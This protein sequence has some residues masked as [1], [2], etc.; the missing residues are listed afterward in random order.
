MVWQFR[1]KQRPVKA[2]KPK[3][4]EVSP[5]PA[6]VIQCQ[7]QMDA[8]GAPEA[9]LVYWTV[10]SGAV[11]FRVKRDDDLLRS[12]G[13]V[14]EEVYALYGDAN[15]PLPVPG[16]TSELASHAAFVDHL[17][18]AMKSQT[19][20][21]ALHAQVR[22]AFRG[23]PAGSASAWLPLHKPAPESAIDTG[24]TSTSHSLGLLSEK[25]TKVWTVWCCHA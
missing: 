15:S 11:A 8:L 12:M 13:R 7:M 21:W 1:G 18:R 16:F 3:G 5:S 25:H 2:S 22:A 17:A 19:P 9:Y 23:D 10:Q 14:L 6:H 20:C 24:P 4:F